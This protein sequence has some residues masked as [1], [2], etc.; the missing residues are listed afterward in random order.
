MNTTDKKHKLLIIS[1]HYPPAGGVGL[2]GAQRAVKFIN[3]LDGFEIAVLTLQPE[4]YPNYIRQDFNRSLPIAGE[5]IYRT[6][7]ID[8]FRF[9]LGIRARLFKKN[10]PA[11][12]PLCESSNPPP[13]PGISKGSQEP[14]KF[15]KLKDLVHD[16]CY[17]PDPASPW[18]PKAVM[19]GLKIIKK[20]RPD[21][22][23]ATG[24]PW[25][26][27]IIA[28]LLHKLSGIPYVCDFRD[29]W[30][31]NPYNAS[32]GKMLDRWNTALEKFVVKNAAIICANTEP[33]RD[34]F[35]RRYPEIPPEKIQV[36]SNG[37]DPE[38]FKHIS[39]PP[40]LP[41][42]YLHLVH[43]GLL[44]GGRSPLPILTAIREL[45]T[46]REASGTKVKFTQIGT[47][48]PAIQSLVA[49][50][51]QYGFFKD[52]GQTPY[53]QCLQHLATADILI[54]IQQGTETQV[55]SKL[56]DYLC[57]GRPI[58]TIT[59]RG[60]A[61][62][63]L[64]EKYSFGDLFEPDDIEGLKEKIRAYSADKLYAG[65][66]TADYRRRDEFNIKNITDKLSTIMTAV[67]RGD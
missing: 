39:K 15:Q 14:S 59:T 10:T 36:L 43:A 52:L 30:T 44:Y 27:L 25:S 5:R 24:M 53:S 20:D 16:L 28:S 32:K 37:Y 60:G 61:L 8:I 46:G 26:S 66:L 56:Y 6:S 45:T 42:E 57:L 35:Y 11:D 40:D 21:I 62:W 65:Q 4:K 58:L 51:D 29:P 22:I 64:I 48:L 63:S 49:E 34:Q 1:Y 54:I 38:D 47:M 33:L 7:H 2:P 55:P 19:K 9:F 17:F 23:F 31:G 50:Y 41:S 12:S 18:I 3:Y 13:F 67:I